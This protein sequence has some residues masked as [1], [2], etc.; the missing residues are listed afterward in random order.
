M[1]RFSNA[2]GRKAECAGAAQ[3]K[4]TQA[5]CITRCCTRGSRRG[6]VAGDLGIG[7][8]QT[9]VPCSYAYFTYIHTL[10]IYMDL[11]VCLSI[12]MCVFTAILWTPPSTSLRARAKPG[13]AFIP[14]AASCPRAS[15]SLVHRAGWAG[16]MHGQ[17]SGSSVMQGGAVTR[18]WLSHA[19]W[20]WP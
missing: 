15:H 1:S 12:S 18:E 19:V 8:N 10:C 2:T 20:R 14:E 11:S 13:C 17:A 7:F 6:P 4:A 5:K 9:C 16:A 3:A